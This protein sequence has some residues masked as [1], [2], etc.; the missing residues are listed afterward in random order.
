M[1]AREQMEKFSRRAVTIPA[2]RIY[3]RAI[4][5]GA[6]KVHCMPN[7][8]ASRS[9]NHPRS[10]GVPPALPVPLPM[11]KRTSS[12]THTTKPARACRSLLDSIV[13][14][15]YRRHARG[16]VALAA[17]ASCLGN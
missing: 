13:K 4:A 11:K 16:R 6:G 10:D 5:P 2:R 14:D 3:R 12:A 8:M 7:P 17:V 9:K 1:R 15:A